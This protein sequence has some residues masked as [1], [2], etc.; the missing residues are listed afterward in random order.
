MAISVSTGHR[1]KAMSAHESVLSLTG[2]TGTFSLGETVSCSGGNNGVGVV[3]AVSGN[4]LYLNPVAGTFGGTIT[5]GTSSATGTYSAITAIG[6]KSFPEIYAGGVILIYSGTKPASA[7]NAVAGTLLGR[8]TLAG[9]SW[10]AGDLTNGLRF[11]T[12]STDGSINKPTGDVWQFTGLANGT[13]TW[14]RL[15]G[16]ATDSG[17]YSASL[18]RIDFSIA[19]FGAD[20]TLADVSVTTGKVYT[21]DQFK[22]TMPGA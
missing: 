11:D 14:G 13:A 9:G 7:D 19:A 5:G 15:V 12:T 6:G 8:V 16:N 4:D 1:I 20:A 21:V 10:S 17:A 2:I 3:V 22:F 18:P